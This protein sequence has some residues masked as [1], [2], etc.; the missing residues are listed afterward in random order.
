[1]STAGTQVPTPANGLAPSMLCS[2]WKVCCWIWSS[3]RIG[4]PSGA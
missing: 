2:S 1:M 3:S 4:S